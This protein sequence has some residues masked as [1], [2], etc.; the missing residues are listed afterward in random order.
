M[1]TKITLEVA[2]RKNVLVHLWPSSKLWARI[3][4]MFKYT[5]VLFFVAMPSQSPSLPFDSVQACLH[6]REWVHFG[7]QANM[8]FYTYSSM[9]CPKRVK[10]FILG[11]VKKISCLSSPTAPIFLPD[12]DF[13]IF[14][15]WEKLVYAKVGI[16][17]LVHSIEM[18]KKVVEKESQQ[19]SLSTV[20]SPLGGP[21]HAHG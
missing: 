14:L 20:S 13:F 4:N 19:V 1:L 7:Q 12:R 10:I 5:R 16:R 11:R 9:L 8:W 3:L 15:F 21:L 6:G 18:S 17:F 2:R